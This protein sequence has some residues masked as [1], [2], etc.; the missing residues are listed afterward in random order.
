[1]AML[2]HVPRQNTEM[3]NE[4]PDDYGLD[5]MT[6]AGANADYELKV[7]KHKTMQDR[8]RK[9]AKQDTAKKRKNPTRRGEPYYAANNADGVTS[10]NDVVTRY[11][12]QTTK[13]RD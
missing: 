10:M 9:V 3:M 4:H 5:G 2:D 13:R 8:K 12:N 1:M 11:F 7:K 6:G